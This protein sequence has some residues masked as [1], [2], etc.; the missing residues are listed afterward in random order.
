MESN[1]FAEARKELFYSTRSLDS[2]NA[3]ALSDSYIPMFDVDLVSGLS[4]QLRNHKGE[5]HRTMPPAG[6]AESDREIAFPLAPIT[7][8]KIFKKGKKSG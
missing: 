4:E 1:K 2:Y 5:R 7:W 3:I 6:T 8:Q